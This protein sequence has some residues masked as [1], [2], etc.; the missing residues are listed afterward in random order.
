MRISVVLNEATDRIEH[1][2]DDGSE[3]VVRT[4]S[5]D[6]QKGNRI[7]DEQRSFS[8]VEQCLGDGFLVI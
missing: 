5:V 1:V 2:G 8:A 4:E 6:E 3:D 7:P